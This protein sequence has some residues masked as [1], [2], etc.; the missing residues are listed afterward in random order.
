MLLFLLST[1]LTLTSLLLPTLSS[2]SPLNPRS[3]VCKNA[4]NTVAG[5]YFNPRS[6]PRSPTAINPGINLGAANPG[7]ATPPMRWCA[8]HSRTFVVMT[9][10]VFTADIAT[11][12]L[13]LSSAYN[14]IL[15]EIQH[16]GDG[17]VQRGAFSFPET[18]SDVAGTSAG[19]AA[20]V[21]GIG[22]LQLNA[23]NENNH[24]M[25]WGVLASAVEAVLDCM[26]NIEEWGTATF[27][28]F[29]GD[30]E[31]GYGVLGRLGGK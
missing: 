23:W 2:P 17:L 15:A 13:F 3:N 11:V 9:I 20:V 16:Y 21:D 19:G 4:P 14:A 8:P 22:E 1:L 10:E 6:V 27:R 30:N 29:D 12:N 31:V 18:G 25:S 28:I 5:T 7:S 26:K 24:Q